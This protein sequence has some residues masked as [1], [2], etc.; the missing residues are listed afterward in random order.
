MEAISRWNLLP[1]LRSVNQKQKRDRLPS[2]E[3]L[4][5]AQARIQDWWDRGY[6][7]ADNP[8]LPE[9]FMTE[10]KA[11]L[12]V[13]EH[14]AA[15]LDDVFAGLYLQQLRLKFDQQIPVW[16]SITVIRGV[17]QIVRRANQRQTVILVDT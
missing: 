1:T 15:R 13:I 12:P 8:V 10:A 4:R 11:T 2:V 9:R 6:L 3:L 16:E 17:D 14:Y 7:R 5:S